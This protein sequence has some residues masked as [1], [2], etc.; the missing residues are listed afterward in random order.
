MQLSELK[1]KIY[2][3]LDDETQAPVTE[4]PVIGTVNLNADVLSELV[5]FVE[6]IRVRVSKLESRVNTF[7]EASAGEPSEE[8]LWDGK[9]SEE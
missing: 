6:D 3:V 2:K 8:V 9:S 4:D 5:D 1:E 7:L